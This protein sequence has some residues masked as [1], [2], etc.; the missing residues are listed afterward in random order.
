MNKAI[1]TC[2]YVLDGSKRYIKYARYN[3][4]LAIDIKVP[5]TNL[6]AAVSGLAF[7]PIN[8]VYRI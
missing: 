4:R 8:H 3:I 7:V 2:M 1:S 5:K 6:A